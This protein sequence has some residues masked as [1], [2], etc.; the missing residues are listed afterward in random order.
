MP[1]SPPLTKPIF[2]IPFGPPEGNSSPSSAG[3]RQKKIIVPVPYVELDGS[4]YFKNYRLLSFKGYFT[5][6]ALD[7]EGTREFKLRDC[8]LSFPLL[9]SF[10]LG[11]WVGERKG[12]YSNIIEVREIDK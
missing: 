7:R 3:S 11:K 10:F 4:G 5:N 1:P 9:Y 8:Y 6:V 12:G 2:L